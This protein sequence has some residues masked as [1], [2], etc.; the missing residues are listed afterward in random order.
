MKHRILSVNT[1]QRHGWINFSPKQGSSTGR[2]NEELPQ[3]IFQCFVI[4]MQLST[5]YDECEMKIQRQT[6]YHSRKCCFAFPFPTKGKGKGR[7]ISSHFLWEHSL[8]FDFFL[9]VSVQTSRRTAKNS[10]VDFFSNPNCRYLWL[11][12]L[13]YQKFVSAI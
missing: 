5:H 6:I 2:N 11:V 10:D 3:V 8:V 12:T 4:P 13:I 1:R 9:R 7:V